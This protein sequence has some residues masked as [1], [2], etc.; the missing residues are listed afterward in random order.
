MAQHWL[1][2][3]EPSAYSWSDL[4]RDH[5][6]AWT[7]VRNFQARNNLRTMKKDDL[8]LFYHSVKDPA[9]VGISKVEREFYPDP[10]ASQGDWSC[11]DLVA[12]TSLVS[13]VPLAEIKADPSLK[14]ISLI[15]QSRLSVMPLTAREY[16][17]IVGKG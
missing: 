16:Q 7:G 14:D 4:V 6:T 11:I 10:T 17:R 12:V 9:V 13:P 15:R 8:V 1:V 3:S 2:K 5:K